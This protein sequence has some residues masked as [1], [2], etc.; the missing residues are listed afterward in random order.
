[1]FL[2]S[3]KGGRRLN[4]SVLRFLLGF[5]IQCGGSNKI[6]TISDTPNKYS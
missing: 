1:M 6:P 2:V 4:S 5:S 3:E